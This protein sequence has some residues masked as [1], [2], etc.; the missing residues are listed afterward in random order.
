MQTYSTRCAPAT[1]PL[2]TSTTATRR[3]GGR[4][5]RGRGRRT[6]RGRR[7]SD[8]SRRPCPRRAPAASPRSISVSRS[9]RRSRAAGSQVVVQRGGEQHAGRRRRARPAGPSARRRR[10]RGVGEQ[11]VEVPVDRPASTGPRRRARRPTT[12]CRG[13]RP[14]VTTSPRPVPSAVP[15]TQR[16][17]HVAAELGGQGEQVVVGGLRAPEPV[18]R[19]QR[20]GGVG[21]AAGQ[22]AGDRDRL[23]DADHAAARTRPW[24]AASRSAARSTMLSPA[25][26]TCV[27]VDVVGDVERHAQPSACGD[28]EVVVQADGLVDGRAAGGSRRRA[29][30][31]TPRCRLILAGARTVVVRAGGK[32]CAV[33]GASPSAIRANSVDVERL[34]A[35]QRV[36]AGVLEGRGR[37]PPRSRRGPAA[38]RAAPCDAGRTRRRRPRR[39]PRGWRWWPAARGGSRRPGRS[40][41]SAP[42]RRRCGPTAPARRTSANHAALTDG[43][44]YTLEPG[45][46]ASRSATSACTIT[47]PR[48]SE[49][50]SVS[51]CSRTGTETL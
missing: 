45:P 7:R 6:R 21:R 14:G 11:L 1:G 44:P 33:I 28:G 30:A 24:C 2:A 40:R 22:P 19:H 4:R 8:R 16:E 27:G 47:R 25:S 39:P 37:R 49:G 43:T 13:R 31:P 10:G 38:H 18:Q 51:M 36:D 29:A 20:G 35:G 34:P 41:R 12:R 50:S 17:R 26:G 9:G 32:S 3:S 5:R 46:A 23:G 42:A 48:S 15:P